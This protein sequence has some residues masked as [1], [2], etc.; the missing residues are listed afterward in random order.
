MQLGCQSLVINPS[1]EVIENPATL[2][3][4]RIICKKETG[5]LHERHNDTKLKS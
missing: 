3:R 2:S 5:N 1:I 4:T